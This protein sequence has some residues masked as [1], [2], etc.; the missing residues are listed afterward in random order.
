MNLPVTGFTDQNR[1]LKEVGINRHFPASSAS[2][3]MGCFLI[4]KQNLAEAS[5]QRAAAA[6]N[7]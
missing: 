4:N 5:M 2:Q 3:L 6:T 1:L 7:C